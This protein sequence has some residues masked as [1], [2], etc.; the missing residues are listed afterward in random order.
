MELIPCMNMLVEPTKFVIKVSNPLSK[1]VLVDQVCRNCPLTIR[2]HCFPANMMLFPFNEFD[3]IL[4][5]DWLTSH[6][7]VVDCGRK[8]IELKCEDGN[9]LQVGPNEPN[10]PPMVMLSLVAE[11]YLRKR[12]KV[13][14]AFC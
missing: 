7:V 1:H 12:Y 13:Y 8:V 11:K 10:K 14:L 5:M 3:V 6:S 9:V 2:G 4:G